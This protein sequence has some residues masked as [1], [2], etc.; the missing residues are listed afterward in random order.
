LTGGLGAD[1]H[2]GGAGDDVFVFSATDES[3]SGPGTRDRI[4][5][6]SV[7]DTIDL[8]QIDA[9]STL[10]GDQAFSFI[11]T[12]AFSAAGQARYWTDGTNTVLL[13]DIDGDGAADGNI[14]L[15]NIDTL[16]VSDLLL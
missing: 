12:A 3:H 8:S 9:N 4:A 13:L 14:A 16:T 15:T 11:G 7:G 2:Y 1:V 5:D 10:A 6:F